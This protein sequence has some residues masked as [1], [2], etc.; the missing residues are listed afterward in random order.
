MYNPDMIRR[1]NRTLYLA[2]ILFEQATMYGKRPEID[3]SA[4]RIFEQALTEFLQKRGVD[5]GPDFP[6]SSD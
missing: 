6:P 5:L 3:R 1:Q 2:D 4:S